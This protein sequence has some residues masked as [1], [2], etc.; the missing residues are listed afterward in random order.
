MR[1]R[2]TRKKTIIP[3]SLGNGKCNIR[4][5]FIP[6]LINAGMHMVFFIF[7]G[8]NFSDFIRLFM[9]FLFFIYPFYYVADILWSMQPVVC[10]I[11]A[12]KIKINRK[13]YMN[14]AQ[15][16]VAREALVPVTISIPV[17]LEEN[18][19]IFE[20]M[21][22]SLMAVKRY[23]S[24]SSEKANVI[25][26]DDGLAIL[27]D[28]ECT[29]EKIEAVMTA[30]SENSR[31]LSEQQIK[32]A[33]RIRFYRK[34]GIAFVAR[35]QNDRAGLFKK[36]SNLN[37]SLKLGA[38][39]SSGASLDELTT[40]AGLFQNGYAEGDIVS[41]DII[42]LLD[43]DSGLNERII[44]AVIPEFANDDKLA[45]VQCATDAVNINEN[46]FSYAYGHQTNN[47]FHNIW[48]CKALQGFFVP[49]VGHNVFIRKSLLEKSGY[50]AENKVS[51]DFD[52]ALCFYGMGYHG[53]Y[54]QLRGLE[55]TEY[56]S[57]TFT[58]ETGRQRRY[59]YGLFEM[60]FD[61]TIVLGKT[62]PCDLFYMIIY[63]FSLINE[64]LLLPSVLIESYFGNIHLLW[65]G[66][67]FC[68][69]CFVLFPFCRSIIMRKRMPKERLEKVGSTVV[70]AFSFVGHSF[71]MFA[72]ACRYLFN[73]VVENSTPFPST[74]VDKLSY[75]FSDGMRLLFRYASQNKWLLV[76]Y[77]LC[78]DRGLFL[79][80][81]RGIETVTVVT[82]CYILFCAV[83]A[84]FLL[85]PQLFAGFTA[86][87]SVSQL[88]MEAEV[89]N[90]S[91]KKV[92]E[93]AKRNAD[94]KIASPQIVQTKEK[95]ELLRS[96]IETFLGSYNKTLQDSVLNEDW[97]EQ[98][99]RDYVFESCIRKDPEGK[100]ELYL[101][102]R[103]KDNAGALLR[104]TH[105]Y[106]QED[107]LEEA[108]LLAKLDHPAIPKVYDSFEKN[109]KRY[110]VRE[111]FQG[112]SLY[113]VIN[114]GGCLGAS[115]IFG[116][117]LKLIDILQYLH[118]Q[119]PPVIHRDIKPQNIIIGNN[120]SVHLIDFGI[121]RTHKESETHDTSV[122]LTSEYASPEQYGFEQTTPLSDIYSLGV[123]ILFMATGNTNRSAL[124]LQI[125]NNRL[126]GLIE[127]CIAF[128]PEERFQSME[129][130]R[131]Y[132][133]RD[134]GQ[135][136]ECKARRLR[137]AIAITTVA[138]LSSVLL[139]GGGFLTGR[140]SADKSG[141][142]SGYDSGYID[143]YN[144]APS[145][146]AAEINNDVNT[147]NN[148]GNTALANGAFAAEGENCVFYIADGKIYRM[149]ANGSGNTLL[150]SGTENTSLSYK[151]GWLYYSAGKQLLQTNIYTDRR[152][153][154]HKS[155]EGSMIIDGDNY[156]IH[157]SGGL[158]SFDPLNGKSSVLN[159]LSN[160]QSLNIKEDKIYFIDRNSHHLYSSGIKGDLIS[161]IMKADFRSICV[162]G[163]SI[164]GVFYN[165]NSGSLIKIELDSGQS[166]ILAE[167]NATMVN[168][169][170]KGI[171]YIDSFDASIY[172]CSPDGRI[173]RKVSK[174]KA[175]DF[176]IAGDWIFYHNEADNDRLWCV[177]WDGANDHSVEE[178]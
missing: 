111:Y 99:Q 120:G 164:Y 178:R 9:S 75:C 149:S 63:F 80:T 26:S 47:L 71:S 135:K 163:D 96:D 49:L 74:N 98:L 37:Y 42:L 133:V 107:A 39:V 115:D 116:I 68:N 126:R 50:W 106:P 86:K 24:F 59:A 103:K 157:H 123:V 6:L 136:N 78:I 169:D 73:K 108:R 94:M 45:Y 16:E 87:G 109:S 64:L 125:I 52:K 129:N 70:V 76:M 53:K 38:A 84:P 153:I 19:V 25:V 154:L 31:S 101:L 130:I 159:N 29:K 93:E 174:N 150:V 160:C 58:E 60:M 83:L 132:I 67:I 122:I 151:N 142:K 100:K 158:Y 85:T 40:A 48:P 162:F 23:Q 41:C 146:Q 55:F 36:S 114:A 170:S 138:V 20:T 46:Y 2:K 173:R 141:F 18:E 112:R 30:Y 92:S 33:E 176:N 171:F 140:R 22:K 175:S 147:G 5:Y 61:G 81:R 113:E 10:D 17:Y 161:E 127:Q 32:A 168:V 35:P 79:L 28:N 110:I 66:F 145:L 172:V 1:V 69:V 155:I 89:M 27:L 4:L 82:Y 119:N 57:R 134:R 148:P 143:G 44:E 167:V 12:G 97:S 105:N 8:R 131:E 90:A 21:A 56:A 152:D 118:A 54:A 77:V 144:S 72:G 104:I 102:R 7:F 34:N 124:E 14:T 62:R 139:Y 51:E 15:R 91:D 88:S 165:N 128:N 156:Y 95:A 166:K 121:A 13:Y 43:K 65:A 137:S 117:T 177:R 11:L 3:E